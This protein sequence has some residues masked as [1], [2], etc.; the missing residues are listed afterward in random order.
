MNENDFANSYLQH[1]ETIKKVL[2]SKKIY[3]EDLLH[4]TYIDLCDWLQTNET[5]KSFGG[6]FMEFYQ[7]R[8]KWQK[9]QDSQLVHCDNAQLAAI[10]IIDETDWEYREELGLKADAILDYVDKTVF[11]TERKPEL[12]RQVLRMWMDGMTYQQ[13]GAQIGMDANSVLHIVQR[14][15]KNIRQ[16]IKNMPK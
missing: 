2:R 12:N 11:P 7:N 6:L 10:N 13:I 14:M 15:I 3:D 16:N 8:Y 5:K 1:E 9:K 4:D